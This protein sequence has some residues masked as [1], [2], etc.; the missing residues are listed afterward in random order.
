MREKTDSSKLKDGRG[1]LSGNTYE[2]WKTARE[3]KSTGTAYAAYDPIQRRTVNL[4]STGEKKVFWVVRFMTPGRIFEQYPMDSQT[5]S[6]ACKEL[7]VRDYSRIL[8]TDLVVEKENGVVAISVK[9]NALSFDPKSKNGQKNITRANVEAQYWEHYGVPHKV[10]Y[11]DEIP[12]DLAMN[13]RDVMFYWDETFV[14]DRTSKLMH[15]I[16]HKAIQIPMDRG[17]IQF[18]TIT[19]KIDVEDLYEAYKRH[20]DDP[21]FSGWRIDLSGGYPLPHTQP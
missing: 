20:Q 8:S 5:V 13:I 18:K 11:A 15:L 14:C 12:S 6:L 3:A 2:A 7:G 17:R 4:L 9:S 1:L 16:A 10:V 19:E 21:D